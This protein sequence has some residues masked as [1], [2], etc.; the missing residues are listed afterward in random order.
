M[1]RGSHYLKLK[2]LASI[3][4]LI[5]VCPN[6][7][8]IIYA[9]CCWAF[10]A[11]AAVEGITQ[12]KTG[13]LISLSEQQLVDC[14]VEGNHGYNGGIMDNAFKYIIQNQGLTSEENYP[15][16]GMDGNCD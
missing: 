6:K 10:S 7:I 5:L 14:S 3:A 8:S 12:I 1:V 13:N 11:V 2:S 16:Q 4:A 9:G 15:Y